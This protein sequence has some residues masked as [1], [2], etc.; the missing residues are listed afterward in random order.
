MS[1]PALTEPE[2]SARGSAAAERDTDPRWA[3]WALVALLIVT[4]VFW[5]IGLGRMGWANDFYAA[6]VQAGTKSWKAFLFGSSD[7]GNS[8]TVDKPPASLW[9]MEISARIFGLNTWSMLLPQVLIGV[10]SVALLYRIVRRQFGPAA[11]LIAGVALALTPVAT[12]MFR[13]N[14]PDALLV[15]LMIA[16]AWAM[17]RAVGDGKTRWLLLC[18]ALV[19]FGFLTKQLQVMLIVPGLALAYLIAGPVRLW[20]RLGQL[21][22]AALALI[23]AGGWWVTLVSV[24]P[25][26]DRPYVGGSTDNS[27]MNLTFGYNGMARLSGGHGGFH[28]GPPQHGPGSPGGG[29]HG[30][31]FGSHAGIT[32][33]FT[34][35]SGGQISWLLPAALIFLVVGIVLCGRVSRTDERRAQYVLWGGWLLGTAAV[36]SFMSG[37]FHDYYTVAMAPAIAALVGVGVTDVWARRHTTW[38]ASVLTA[39]VAV[40]AVWSWVLL[41][42]SPGFVPPLRWV[43]LVGGLLAAAAVA[44]RYGVRADRFS[45]R[46]GWLGATLAAAAAVA[47][48]LAYCIQT[49]STTHIGG[50][51]VAGPAVAGSHLPGMAPRDPGEPD[52]PGGGNWWGQAPSQQI[53]QALK[54]TGAGFT[55]AAATSGANE[56]AG[57]QLATGEAVMPVGGFSG[58]DPSP[59][60][61]QFQKLVADGRIHYYIEGHHPGWR[62][63]DDA[64]KSRRPD[65]EGDKIADWV[66]NTFPAIKADGVTYWDLTAPRS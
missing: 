22:A 21:A 17:M 66:K 47:G 55:W 1:A 63:D 9:P 54:Q 49:V 11:G 26:A 31:S 7:A 3:R 57:Y 65:T 20:R 53:V 18:G 13:Y 25:A 30:F 27:F 40:T 29:G 60:L 45:A 43:V 16:A 36:L 35:V 23:V 42:R 39:T 51:I 6:A 33:L 52:A 14:N 41:G 12:L 64:E 8:I 10:A 34:N 19:G 58:R 32:R 37:T 4:A 48:P 15:F 61:A 28:G 38:V 59:T 24:T 46:I 50:M 44:L 2:A 62:G 56:A 5:S